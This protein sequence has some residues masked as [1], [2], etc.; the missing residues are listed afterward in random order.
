MKAWQMICLFLFLSAAAQL[1]AGYPIFKLTESPELMHGY[2]QCDWDAEQ[3]TR[4]F[5]LHTQLPTLYVQGGGCNVSLPPES[6]D[7]EPAIGILGDY[8][9][10]SG[11][12]QFWLESTSSAAF[13]C[14]AGKSELITLIYD[15][16]GIMVGF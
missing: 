8:F 3:E 9:S 11:A 12:C 1:R 2:V 13:M 15:V 5:S 16:C 14:T 10:S 4:R 7:C 6:T